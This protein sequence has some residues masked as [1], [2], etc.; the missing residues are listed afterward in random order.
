M[1]VVI[2]PGMTWQDISPADAAGI[3]CREHPE[4]IPPLNERGE[5]CP[6]PW[7]PQS[8]K[9]APMGQ[10]HCGYCGAMCVAGSPH[11]DYRGDMLAEAVAA[12][13]PKVV[14]P[15]DGTGGYSPLCSCRK[16]LGR[17]P[18]G[19]EAQFAWARHLVEAL[20]SAALKM[21]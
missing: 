9:G 2:E 12:H 1:G 5:P 19:M 4:L 14:V 8:L 20:T 16:D 13:F 21:G 15:A 3:S 6:W 10:Y 18:D 17:Y 11:P 7:E